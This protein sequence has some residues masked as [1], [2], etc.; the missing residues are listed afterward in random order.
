MEG[1]ASLEELTLQS[2]EVPPRPWHLQLR[3]DGL[4][5]RPAE[6]DPIDL[7]RPEVE[8][9]TEIVPLWGGQSVLVVR[10]RKRKKVQ[11]KLTPDQRMAVEAWLGPPT[12]NQLRAVL[13]RRYAFGLPIAILFLLLSIPLPADPAIGAA[14]HPFDPIWA[15]LGV[16]LLLLWVASRLRPS[17]VLLLLDAAW[18]LV[19]ALLHVRD[20]LAG[21]A[22]AFV[23][24]L[25]ALGVYLA[26]T[27]VKQFKRYRNATTTAAAG[28]RP[29]NPSLQRTPPG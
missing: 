21:T 23:L 11:L 22:S 18:F 26:I 15:T 25:V 16:G 28:A 29:P 24:L 5:L 20:L 19:M 14:A 4:Q 12:I 3:S 1:E 7:S 13:R 2:I 9:V 8:S 17:P 27:G 10:A 6:G